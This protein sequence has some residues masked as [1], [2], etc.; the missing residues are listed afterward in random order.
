MKERDA[1]FF[2][3]LWRRVAVTAVCA[4]WAVLELFGRDPMW[5]A[6]TVGLTAYSVWSFFI[7][8]PK[9]VPP[10]PGQPPKITGDQDVPP[11]A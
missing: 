8:F 3:P 10:V 7:S 9:D 4:G 6:I 1:A 11:S 5:I 2:R